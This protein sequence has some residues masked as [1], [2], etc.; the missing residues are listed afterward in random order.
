ML[1]PPGHV[2]LTI[3][4]H[5]DATKYSLVMLRVSK[6]GI[7]NYQPVREVKTNRVL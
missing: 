3:I 7:E 1:P 5:K 2:F 4:T 6:L